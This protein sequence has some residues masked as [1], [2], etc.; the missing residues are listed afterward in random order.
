MAKQDAHPNLI[1]AMHGINQQSASVLANGLTT[2]IQNAISVGWGAAVV[3]ALSTPALWPA[4]AVASIFGVAG[5]LHNKEEQKKAAEFAAMVQKAAGDVT[6]S[7]EL[8]K[9]IADGRITLNIDL[10]ELVKADLAEAVSIAVEAKQRPSLELLQRINAAIGRAKQDTAG[11]QADQK[12]LL[13]FAETTELLLRHVKELAERAVTVLNSRLSGRGMLPPGNDPA[14]LAAYRQ[15]IHEHVKAQVENAQDRYLPLIN[16]DTGLA[17][18]FDALVGGSRF[19]A[20][21]SDRFAAV[22][23]QFGSLSPDARAAL[24]DALPQVASCIG[25]LQTSADSLPHT[26]TA[27]AVAASVMA[28]AGPS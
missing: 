4:V 18:R 7:H 17:E 3:A 15:W 6:S 26:L 12:N 23:S 16:I 21:A 20:E 2:I 24:A 10:D 5:W 14:A 9:R 8:L 1:G 19:T 28:I 11:V 27:S 25:Q 13:I 22:R